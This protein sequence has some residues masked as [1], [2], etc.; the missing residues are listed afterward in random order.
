MALYLLQ[1]N[2]FCISRKHFPSAN[3]IDNTCYRFQSNTSL[4]VDRRRNLLGIYYKA[5]KA[6]VLW[7]LE[8]GGSVETENQDE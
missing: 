3:I 8:G 6:G 4:L 2:D 5:I 7:E 1:S